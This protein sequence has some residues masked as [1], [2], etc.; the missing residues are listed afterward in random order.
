[1]LVGSV[2]PGSAAEHA[3]LHVGDTI[4][5][6]QGRA[7]GGE[8]QQQLMRLNPGETLSVKVRS[9]R[10]GDREL[11][12]IV[13]TREEISYEV[14]DLDQITAEQWTR[15]AAWLKGEA[16]SDSAGFSEPAGTAK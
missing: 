5:E 7:P 14:K 15:R 10:G 2:T 9:R 12:W 1:M 16:E 3:G 11:K 6:L 8:S 4:I 13:G